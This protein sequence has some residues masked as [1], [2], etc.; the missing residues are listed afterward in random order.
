MP[1]A[2]A[3]WRTWPTT[4]A[5][6]GL[7]L[8]S[9]HFHRSMRM[10]LCRSDAPQRR[11]HCLWTDHTGT[12]CIFSQLALE[13]QKAYRFMKAAKGH[14]AKQCDGALADRPLSALAL[15]TV[16][17]AAHQGRR[18]SPHGLQVRRG[19]ILAATLQRSRMVAW[20][21]RLS[22]KTATLQP[23]PPLTNTGARG[24]YGL[25][26]TQP[27]DHLLVLGNLGIHADAG[28]GTGAAPN[29]YLQH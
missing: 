29:T 7:A 25:Y 9:L 16:T 19:D 4:P 18:C 23:L 13:P 8:F 3:S 20:Y 22:S 14:L 6:H 5:L 24:G 26:G 28:V 21:W 12:R 15:A 2:A 17:A 10:R 1:L 11:S 27:A